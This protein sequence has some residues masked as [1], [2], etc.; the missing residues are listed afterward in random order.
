MDIQRLRQ[1]FG[2]DQYRLYYDNLSKDPGSLSNL[3]QDLPNY[4]QHAVSIFSLPQDWLWCESWCSDTAKSKAK[5]IDLCNN[6]M[7][8]EHKLES[9]KRIIPEWVDYDKEAQKLAEELY[10]KGLLNYTV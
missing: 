1:V 4:S 10:E 5:T 3:D 9:A 6:P 7:T 8:K 2:G